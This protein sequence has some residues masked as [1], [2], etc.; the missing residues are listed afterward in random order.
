[1]ILVR[2]V[3]DFT[4]SSEAGPGG[5]AGPIPDL[6]RSGMGFHLRTEC[7][8]PLGRASTVASGMRFDEG[9]DGE[10]PPRA[11]T[12]AALTEARLATV[13]RALGRLEE[14]QALD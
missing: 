11:A 14:A 8:A 1:M 5:T 4:L 12:W 9:R 13:L 6:K 2:I 10:E 7:I 3:S